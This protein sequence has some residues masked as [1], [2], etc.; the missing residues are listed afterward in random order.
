M[1]KLNIITLARTIRLNVGNKIS[2]KN[3]EKLTTILIRY[4]IYNGRKCISK[5][6]FNDSIKHINKYETKFICNR[7]SLSSNN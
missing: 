6:E 5:T 2:R 3:R 7:E 4:N 1:W